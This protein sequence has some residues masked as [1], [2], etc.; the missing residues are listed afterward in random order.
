MCIFLSPVISEPH[1]SGVIIHSWALKP[2]NKHPKNGFSY[3]KEISQVYVYYS[4]RE[5]EIPLPSS[6]TE[7]IQ[8]YT[9]FEGNCFPLVWSS[10]LDSKWRC[11]EREMREKGEW[12]STAYQASQGFSRLVSDQNLQGRRKDCSLFSAFVLSKCSDHCPNFS[13]VAETG[14]YLLPNLWTVWTQRTPAQRLRASLM[15]TWLLHTCLS[16]GLGPAL[17]LLG[18]QQGYNLALL[19]S[20]AF[21]KPQRKNISLSPLPT[22]S[23]DSKLS[24]L[25]SRS[26]PFTGVTVEI[27]TSSWNCIPSSEGLAF[28]FDPGKTTVSRCSWPTLAQFSRPEWFNLIP[29]HLPDT[30]RSVQ[31][32]LGQI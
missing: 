2:G 3:S 14:H 22:S 17:S 25:V 27:S 32:E 9:C 23:Q 12:R 21:L 15:L 19:L 26:A 30:H 20:P 4:P 10:I 13:K 1:I 29:Q 24:F 28:F 6:G 16:P 18:L 7:P 31:T 5:M 8:L 11:R